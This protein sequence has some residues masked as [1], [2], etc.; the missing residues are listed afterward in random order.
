MESAP[1]ELT[2]STVLIVFMAIV[3]LSADHAYG[4][5][6]ISNSLRINDL[7]VLYTVKFAS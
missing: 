2:D 4:V 5:R 3:L 1:L 7:V 6:P